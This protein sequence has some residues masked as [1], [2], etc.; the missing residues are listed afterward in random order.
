MG[1]HLTARAQPRWMSPLASRALGL[2]SAFLYDGKQHKFLRRP[3][4]QPGRGMRKSEGFILSAT[5]LLRQAWREVWQSPGILLLAF[6]YLVV[7]TAFEYFFISR[8]GPSLGQWLQ[9]ISPTTVTQ[10]P[11]L[12][13]SMWVKLILVYLTMLLIISPF[14]L[15][16][17]YGGA[18]ANL[19]E[20]KAMQFFAFFRFAVRFF[21]RSLGLVVLAV[22]SLAVVLGILLLGSYGIGLVAQHL[23]AGG[24]VLSGAGSIVA[25]AVIFWWIAFMLAW[26]GELYF[27]LDPFW[28]AF[29]SAVLWVFHHLGFCLRWIFLVVGL[30]ILAF[31][32]ISVFA[33]IPLVGPV[34]S[35]F[36]SGVMMA[37][38]AT[39]AAVLNRESVRHET[40][41]PV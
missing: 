35:L 16:G 25:I 1:I 23:G 10:F 17:L 5:G 30:F 14:S 40:R 31:L 11:P 32:L 12:A 20:R 8:L 41:P 9:Q 38:L 28:T 19:R 7:T 26:L 34:L 6:W 2:A 36:G 15:G 39:L 22:L 24:V 4:P 27:G 33:A 13:P 37:M 29:R 21:W 18:A 3:L